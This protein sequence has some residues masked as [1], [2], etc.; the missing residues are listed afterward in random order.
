MPE[1]PW[2]VKIG[3]SYVPCHWKGF[4]FITALVALFLTSVGILHL[5]AELLNTP[6]I[7]DLSVASFAAVLLVG[8]RTAERH[9][10]KI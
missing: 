8:L 9:S 10:R 2:F 6:W 1:E 3:W 7:S 4:A 5:L